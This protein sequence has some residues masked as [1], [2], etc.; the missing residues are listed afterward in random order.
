[1]LKAV[2]TRKHFCL[3]NSICQSPLLL[4]QLF[5]RSDMQA[6]EFQKLHQ[7][8]AFGNVSGEGLYYLT[9]ISKY[10]VKKVMGP[11]SILTKIISDTIQPLHSRSWGTKKFVHHI[12]MHQ[13]SIA[14]L[15]RIV[16]STYQFQC[17]WMTISMRH[18]QDIFFCSPNLANTL[19]TAFS[20]QHEFSEIQKPFVLNVHVLL[21]FINTVG[22]SGS[23]VIKQPRLWVTLISKGIP[24]LYHVKRPKQWIP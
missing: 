10:V 9:H 17:N 1:M 16:S 7:L 6:Y 12:E 3:H 14:G 18:K 8:S 2:V 15:H 4:G 5:E 23:N 21:C 20:E 24:L 13:K 19:T 22:W 11:F